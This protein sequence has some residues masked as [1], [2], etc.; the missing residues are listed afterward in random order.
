MCALL[1]PDAGDRPSGRHP[2]R[3]LMGYPRTTCIWS[4]ATVVSLLTCALLNHGCV[5][6]CRAPGYDAG[7]QFKITVLSWRE[8]ES[9]CPD[10][11]LAP[12]DSF[13]LTAGNILKAWV[14]QDQCDVRSARAEVPS[15]AARTLTTCRETPLQ[16]GLECNGR[17]LSPCACQGP[18]MEPSCGVAATIDI[19]LP[20]IERGRDTFEEGLLR[21]WWTN[22]GD[23][24]NPGCGIAM[25]NVRIERL[26]P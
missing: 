4:P 23:G 17:S 19:G 11:G 5:S 6:P 26:S 10:I 22:A 20:F 24:C 13:V 25:Y 7:E 16:L 12:G 9:V 18:R 8:G 3:R 1:P 21:V 2:E 14:G 15:F